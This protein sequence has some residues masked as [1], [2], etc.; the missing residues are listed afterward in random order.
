[1][2]KGDLPR[3]IYH[4]VYSKIRRYETALVGRGKIESW[5]KVF[6]KLFRQSQLP[7][8]SVNLSFTISNIQNELTDFLGRG[9]IESWARW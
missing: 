7:C 1:M 4:R 3:V 5:A 6:I 9:K 8:K 2:P